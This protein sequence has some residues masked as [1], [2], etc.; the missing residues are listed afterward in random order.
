MFNKKIKIAFLGGGINSAVG[1]AHRIA[2]EMD[3]RY[4]LVAG[5]F[6]R[7]NELNQLTANEYGVDESRVYKN[8]DELIKNEKNQIDLMCI[9]TPT[10]N[11]KEEVLKCLENNIAVISEKALAQS[12]KDI[13]EI[14]ELL[15]KTN[16]FLAVT[17]N[18]TGYPMLRELKNIILNGQLG[19]INQIHIEMPQ[20][21]FIKLD[22][23]DKP[24]IPQDWRLKD[25]DNL[26][27]M[28]LDLGTHTHDL[29]SF[30]TGEEPIEL[31]S[32]QNS[33][34]SFEQV[35]DNSISI[36]K[37]TN[38]IVSNIWFSKS[39]LGYRNGLR[40]RVFGKKGSAEW[41]QLDPENL[42]IND[43]KGTRN[44]LDRG[45][46]DIDIAS[47]LRY[48]RFKAGHPSG[49]IEAFANHYSDIADYFLKLNN[50]EN[51]Y[52]FGIDDALEGIKMLEA[53]TKSSK[54][55]KWERI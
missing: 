46:L 25:N 50:N 35:I 51:R 23:M 19:E 1:R 15:I 30:L 31:V 34:G 20:E 17:Y 26:P 55:L 49:F 29:T 37:Y 40:V 38:N 42:Y 16:G 32:I 18:Y 47:K 7:N 52:V 27:I 3:K 24:F 9:L 8:L 43:N 21:S 48:N 39:A 45:S 54:N 13:L 14:K 36:A 12:S 41:Y 53:M 6:S 33:F 28:S 11:H 5:C 10:P 2:I 44:I 4:E 22:K